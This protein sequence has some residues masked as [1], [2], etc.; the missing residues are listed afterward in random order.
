MSA[1]DPCFRGKEGKPPEGSQQVSGVPAREVCTSGRPFKQGISGKK[2]P[3]P[4]KTY[5]PRRVSGGMQDRNRLCP[6]CYG[7]AILHG[8][9]RH[10]EILGV[11]TPCHALTG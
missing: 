10:G 7:I 2:H 6:Q 3:F 11:I 1:Q 4:V 5:A 8:L 9:F